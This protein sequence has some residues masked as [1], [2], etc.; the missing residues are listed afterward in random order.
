MKS[1]YHFVILYQQVKELG[2]FVQNCA[3]LGQDL[4]KIFAVYWYLG[5]DNVTVPETWP[6]EYYTSINKDQPI[7]VSFNGTQAPVYI[8]VRFIFI[9]SRTLIS[10]NVGYKQ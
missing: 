7:D 2:V 9:Y 6:K 10:V 4:K 3:C 8:S 5:Q 1:C